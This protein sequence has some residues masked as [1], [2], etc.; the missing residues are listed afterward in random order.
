M[1][2]IAD[3]LMEIQH[4]DLPALRDM[5]NSNDSKT[6]TAYTT[7]DN[8]IRWLQ[9]GPEET[10]YIKFFCLNGDFADGTFAVTVSIISFSTC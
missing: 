9:Q 1:A 3:H 8:Y 10:K 4:K 6:H 2:I 7:I 5:Y